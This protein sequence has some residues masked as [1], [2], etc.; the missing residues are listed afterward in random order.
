MD[1]NK[2][3]CRNCGK[4]GHQY[5]KCYKPITSIGIICLKCD[6]FDLNNILEINKKNGIIYNKYNFQKI[7]NNKLKKKL[8]QNINFLMICRKYSH[9]FTGLMRGNYNLNTL[10]DVDHIK[11]IFKYITHEELLK[12]TNSSFDDIWNSLWFDKKYYNYSKQ[13]Y[14]KLMNGF[15]IIDNN[16]SYLFNL[17]YFLNGIIFWNE[18]EWEFP[19]GKRNNTE[20]DIECAVREFNEET[21][22]QKND[23]L[24]L[25][26]T[27]SISEI[28]MGHNSINYKY[29]FFLAQS[30]KNCKNIGIANDF[31]KSEIS[32]IKW[33]NYNEALYK[34]RNYNTERKELIKRIFN[35]I[36]FHI[37]HYQNL[38][39][40]KHIN[41]INNIT[42]TSILTLE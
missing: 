23:Y 8:Q 28:F 26:N 15:Y 14:L 20:T 42:P 30:N 3:Y 9:S 2:Y 32:D 10:S 33:F 27:N 31:Q 36:F 19:K 1:V 21:D 4:Y 34:I 12:I 40:E 17:N 5:K 37:Y 7:N 25:K 35:F 11:K 16:F 38:L 6:E 13:K 41:I 29:T 39:L 18:P 22:L 24:L